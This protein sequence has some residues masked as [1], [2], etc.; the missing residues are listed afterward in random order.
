MNK[1]QLKATF[2]PCH[3]RTTPKTLCRLLFTISIITSQTI[4]G[5]TLVAL[6]SRT[7]LSSLS[8]V[9]IG[10]AQN[11]SSNIGG[12]LSVPSVRVNSAKDSV[13]FTKNRK[14][15]VIASKLTN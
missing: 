14:N 9:I 2:L 6:I 5:A 12:T 15:G 7:L 1:Q 13:R 10:R 4:L 3:Y 8:K 11:S